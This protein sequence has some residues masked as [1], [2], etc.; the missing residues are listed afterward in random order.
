MHAVDARR[1][2][3]QHEV[4]VPGVFASR[5]RLVAGVLVE[6]KRVHATQVCWIPD[7][8]FWRDQ[9]ISVSFPRPNLDASRQGTS[10]LVM[11]SKSST[12]VTI[13]RANP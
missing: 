11:A 6:G 9:D 10:V 5:T 2:H 4:S 7:Q 1:S 3:G 12:H 13:S 8:F